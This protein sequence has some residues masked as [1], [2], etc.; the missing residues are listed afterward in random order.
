MPPNLVKKST[1]SLK[2]A[3]TVHKVSKPVKK[4]TAKTKKAAKPTTPRPA[5]EDTKDHELPPDDILNL[6]RKLAGM[7]AVSTAE[8]SV[9]G[10]VCVCTNPDI[11]SAPGS[12]CL[13]G[14]VSES[15]E[16][17]DGNS[18]VVL[19]F[20]CEYGYDSDGEEWLCGLPPLSP[21][22]N[23]CHPYVYMDFCNRAE[24]NAQRKRYNALKHDIDQLKIEHGLAQAKVAK[25]DRDLC[26]LNVA[27][28]ALLG[29]HTMVQLE[30]RTYAGSMKPAMK[31]RNTTI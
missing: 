12:D 27:W 8:D 14:V 21:H 22:R 3:K 29:D 16:P 6:V 31:Q 19:G 25:Y 26:D 7:N 18:D 15:D 13:C 17:S 24:I 28:E 2:R 23:Y 10:D 11:D 4:A 9:P 20:P 5:V 30:L 1:G